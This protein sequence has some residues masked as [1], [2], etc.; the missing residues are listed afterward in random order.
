MYK[1]MKCSHNRLQIVQSVL[2][3]L[4]NQFQNVTITIPRS[5]YVRILMLNSQ[6]HNDKLLSY[7]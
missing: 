3:G 5:Y 2:R 7:L 6:R 4:E 1:H